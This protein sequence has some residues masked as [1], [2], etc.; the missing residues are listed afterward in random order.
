MEIML[1]FMESYPTS[2]L[3][4]GRALGLLTLVISIYIGRTRSKQSVPDNVADAG[5]MNPL[6]RVCIGSFT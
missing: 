5:E 4:I 1:S 3:I 2:M 6:T